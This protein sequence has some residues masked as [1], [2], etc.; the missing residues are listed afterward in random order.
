MGLNSAGVKLGL[1]KTDYAADH[2]AGTD[3]VFFCFGKRF[4]RMTWGE[5]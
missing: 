2:N 5:I 3:V 4:S 1:T